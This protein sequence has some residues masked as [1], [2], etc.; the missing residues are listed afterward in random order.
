MEDAGAEVKEEME[1]VEEHTYED[2]ER[3]MG[4]EKEEKE[5]PIDEDK[6]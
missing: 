4:E 3:T 5:V 6:P 1:K 2:E